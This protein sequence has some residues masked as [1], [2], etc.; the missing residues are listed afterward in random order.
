MEKARIGENSSKVWRVL[1]EMKKISVH[2]LCTI[3]NLAIEDVMLAI[4]WLAREN[5]IFIEKREDTIYISN[6]SEYY[7]C[8]G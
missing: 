5:C 7:F 1:N 2:G 4:G 6:G 3:T 8:F